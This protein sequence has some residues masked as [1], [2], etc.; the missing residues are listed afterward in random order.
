MEEFVASDYF[1]RDLLAERFFGKF[2][3]Q[4]ETFHREQIIADREWLQSV[5]F[6]DFVRQGG[7]DLG[8]LS[9]Q[10]FGCGEHTNVVILYPSLG[11]AP[12]LERSRRLVHLTQQEL[13]PLLGKALAVAGE[14]GWSNLPPRWRQTLDCLLEGDSEKQVALRLGI[15]QL[16]IHQYVKGLY[17]HFG[18]SS[19]GELLAFFLR[20]YRRADPP[21][22]IPSTQT[23]PDSASSPP[24]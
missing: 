3:V 9:R 17:Q 24:L 4:A 6:N 5:V 2:P 10:T 19:R 13:G 23:L 22:P 1:G 14:P 21:Q 15:S 11:K 20:R 7:L 16:T 8:I 18:V 12:L